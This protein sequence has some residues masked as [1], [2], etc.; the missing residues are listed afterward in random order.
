MERDGN[1]CC[2]P[3]HKN[4]KDAEVY[5]WFVVLKI[6]TEYEILTSLLVFEI[7]KRGKVHIRPL[8]LQVQ[9]ER[10]VHIT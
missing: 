6:K 5:I 10:E 2:I 7:H 3:I 8:V 1:I 4:T 9:T